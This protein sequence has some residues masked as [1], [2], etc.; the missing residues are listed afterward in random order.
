ME[1]DPSL[2]QLGD[3]MLLQSDGTH[4]RLSP[5]VPFCPCLLAILWV[6]V[7]VCIC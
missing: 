3:L 1:G 7:P 2:E 4:P 6:V 5:V